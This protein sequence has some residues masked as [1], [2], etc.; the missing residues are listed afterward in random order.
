VEPL[1]AW[2]ATTLAGNG[3]NSFSDGGGSGAGFYYPAGMSAGSGLIPTGILNI[4]SVVSYGGPNPAGY[5]LRPFKYI[6]PDKYDEVLA[7]M[8]EYNDATVESQLKQMF[9][10][11]KLKFSVYNSSKDLPDSYLPY[12]YWIDGKALIIDKSLFD[13]IRKDLE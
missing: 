11:E 5:D 9:N 12:E 6:T 7:I 8:F 1:C 2:S 10:Y 13:S 3:A 4:S